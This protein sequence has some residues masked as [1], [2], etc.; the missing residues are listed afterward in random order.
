MKPDAWQV[1]KKKIINVVI[2][3]D[4]GPYFKLLVE[5]KSQN[6]AY[7]AIPKPVHLPGEVKV[8]DL[9][10]L[11]GLA[12]PENLQKKA[13]KYIYSLEVDDNARALLE[14]TRS[15][16]DKQIIIIFDNFL[17]DLP[18]D[19]INDFAELLKSFKKKTVIYFTK[20]IS[21]STKIA[22]KRDF[23]HRCTNEGHSY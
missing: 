1:I 5:L 19:L 14:I 4:R 10:G 2:T 7:V 21:I 3:T 9:L 11:F 17:A 12:V 22:D 8:K 15:L 13:D 6:T 23:V 20:T 16:A 18:D